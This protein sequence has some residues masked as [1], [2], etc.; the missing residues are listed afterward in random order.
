[1]LLRRA[2]P[3]LLVS[4]LGATG[5]L[6]A[7][8]ASAATAATP[9]TYVALGDSYA[10]GFGLPL[11]ATLTGQP[12]AGCEQTTLDYPHRLATSL[13]LALTDVTCSGAVTGDFSA[14]QAV[15]PM[16]DPPAQLDVFKTIQP[17]L[18]SITIGGN[19]LGFSAIAQACIA[20]TKNGPT[21][22]TAAT[23]TP[24]LSC[25]DYFANAGKADDPY[26]RIPEVTAKVRAAIAAVQAAAPNAKVVVIGYPAIAP[27][28]ANTP[29]GGCFTANALP[30]PVP[31]PGLPVPLVTALPFTDIDI[32]YLQ[33]L[34]QQLN[35]AIGQQAT[36][37]GASYAD[38]YPTSLAHSACSPEATR[39]VEP[40]I[41]GGGGT[42]VLHPSLAGTQAM[43]NALSPVVEA[44]LAPAAPT[45]T[46]AP[47]TTTAAPVTTAA[48]TTT[49]TT[50]V[51]AVTTPVRPQA[52]RV[53]ANTGP[54]PIGPLLAVA[55]AF[56]T[57]GAVM[58]A[59][60]GRRRR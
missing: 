14:P 45:T 25:K 34:Q 7:P 57:A 48:P 13:G 18:V 17:D 30:T 43:A 12:V 35:T 54:A 49:T 15:T 53:L 52:S 47:P 10:A 22:A 11:P 60:P 4:A 50:A 32:P 9:P 42:N 59:G 2:V 19:D 55:G 5:V 56:L 16:P 31:V 28:A 24:S 29:E 23:K 8:A 20:L 26:A 33:V 37:R 51:V 6:L 27:D 1:M 41:P 44:L 46:T 39:W 3:A 58:V 40:V 38:V 36:E 21:L